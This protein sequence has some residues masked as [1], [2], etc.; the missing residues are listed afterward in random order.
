MAVEDT[1]C[2]IRWM[3]EN[4]GRLGVDPSRI[5][6]A[7]G[8]AGGHLAAFA[9]LTPGRYEGAGGHAGQSSRVQAAVCWYPATQVDLPGTSPGTAKAVL[10]LLGDAT[11]AEASPLTHITPDAPPTLVLQGSEDVL[12]PLA[13][14]RRFVDRAREAGV[15]VEMDVRSGG[16]H[17][18]DLIDEAEW[19][20]SFAR[21][22]E[23]LS[24]KLGA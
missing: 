2:A 22:G 16:V 17:G 12:T 19:Q 5:A 20:A 23:W 4:A 21:V 3:R 15:D 1:K 11:V 24:R 13:M 9:A 14:V 6:I 18:Y 7:G 8:S 10:E